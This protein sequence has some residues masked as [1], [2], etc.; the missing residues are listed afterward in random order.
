MVRWTRTEYPVQGVGPPIT[1]ADQGLRQTLTHV[2]AAQ[3]PDADAKVCIF[4]LSSEK[5]G[6][7]WMKKT[8]IFLGI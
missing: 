5:K 6:N 4:S 3:S 7:N 1:T 2:A 8:V